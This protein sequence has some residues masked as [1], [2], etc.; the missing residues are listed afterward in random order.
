MPTVIEDNPYYKPLCNHP[1]HNP[2]A[3]IVIPPGKQMRHTCPA[4]GHVTIVVYNS[5]HME[6]GGN[7]V[8]DTPKI[9]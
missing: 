2:P 3:D 8:L 9:T 7:G 6:L 1:E 4:C 5:P